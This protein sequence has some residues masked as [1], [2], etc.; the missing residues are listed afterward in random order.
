MA[1]N[2]IRVGYDRVEQ[3]R[4]VVSGDGLERNFLEEGLPTC[5]QAQ[6][7]CLHAWSIYNLQLWVDEGRD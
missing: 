5:I 1:K 7:E 6:F 2:S 4:E 3:F